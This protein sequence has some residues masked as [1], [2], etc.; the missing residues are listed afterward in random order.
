MLTLNGFKKMVKKPTTDSGTLIDHVNVS[1]KMTVTTD[2]TDATVVIMT[3]H[4]VQYAFKS[5]IF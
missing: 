5:N 3:M 4:Y 2:Y 1:Q